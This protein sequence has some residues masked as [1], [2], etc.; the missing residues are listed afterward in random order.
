MFG[1]YLL[2]LAWAAFLLPVLLTTIS[3]RFLVWTMERMEICAG[4]VAG[5]FTAGFIGIIIIAIQLICKFLE[6]LF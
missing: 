5:V 1:V 3:D 6:W 4:Y 2:L